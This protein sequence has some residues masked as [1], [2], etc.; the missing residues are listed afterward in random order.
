MHVA[1]IDAHWEIESRNTCHIYEPLDTKAPPDARPYVQMYY[2]DFYDVTGNKK[3][4]S[5]VHKHDLACGVPLVAMLPKSDCAWE[6]VSGQV[7]YR[8]GIG[9]CMV[10][11]AQ[12]H[13]RLAKWVT[14]GL[15]YFKNPEK[16]L[17]DAAEGRP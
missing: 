10:W 17:F 14:G 6:I 4:D 7:R 5:A 16:K 9:W 2:V 8:K 11:Y 12:R 1:F 3:V 15:E 13:S